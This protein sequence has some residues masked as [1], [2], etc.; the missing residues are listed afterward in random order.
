MPRAFKTTT[1]SVSGVSSSASREIAASLGID[2]KVNSLGWAL[3]AGIKKAAP[4][5]IGSV[6]SVVQDLQVS[7]EVE[8]DESGRPTHVVMHFGRAAMRLALDEA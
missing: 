8:C 6:A 3:A 4:D 7:S 2:A 5:L 1:V